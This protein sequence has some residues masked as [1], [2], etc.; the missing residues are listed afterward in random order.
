MLFSTISH[1]NF[2]HFSKCS[3]TSLE[4]Q[5]FQEFLTYP[6]LLPEEKNGVSPLFEAPSAHYS[7]GHPFLE[8][9]SFGTEFDC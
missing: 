5:F 9:S 1:V 3:F 6:I 4:L 8:V 7:T 2:P